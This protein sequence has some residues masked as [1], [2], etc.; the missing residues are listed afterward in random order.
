MDDAMPVTCVK[1]PF[2]EVAARRLGLSLVVV[3]FGAATGPRP[4]DPH[5]LPGV[6]RPRPRAAR[7]VPAE[8]GH[9]GR[10]GGYTA[11]NG[12]NSV[13]S[14]VASAD[15]Q[16][17][18]LR[19][20]GGR[21]R[22][23]HPEPDPADDLDPRRRQHGQR[24][25]LRLDDDARLR[26]RPITAGHG[27]HLRLRPGPARPRRL[28]AP[29]RPSSAARSPEP[30]PPAGI[31][32]NQPITRVGAVATS[33]P[34]CTAPDGRLRDDHGATPP[35]TTARSRS[36]DGERRSTTRCRGPGVNGTGAITRSRSSGST[37]ATGSCPAAGP[38]SFVH[39][40][41]PKCAAGCATGA[42]T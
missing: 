15:G 38:V 26:R 19:P 10:G 32:V 36:R 18:L 30:A 24:R 6:L 1:R 35:R 14:A 22:G 4:A 17:H 2:R 20:L 8:P 9:H 41:D 28:R 39:N 13:V 31:A 7:L 23:R 34:R 21:A 11:G 37:A 40:Q 27:H 42:T 25:R 5:R 16:R 3:A 12:M 33:P 29:G